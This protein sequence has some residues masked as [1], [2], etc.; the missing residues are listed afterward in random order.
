MSIASPI[1]WAGGKKYLAR[2]IIDIMKTRPHI[3]YCEPYCGGCQVLFA[4]DP[5]WN[6]SHQPGAAHAGCSEL[7]N[8][9]AG[10]LFNFWN[11][12]RIEVLFDRFVRTVNLIP[13]AEQAWDELEPIKLYDAG[14]PVTRAISFFIRCRQ[15]RGGES[16]DFVTPVRTRTRRRMQDHVSAYLSAVDGLY[17]V[18]E[19]LRRVLMLNRPALD[20]IR[21]ED[22]PGT[23]FYL[24][25]P[26][27]HC[28]RIVKHLYEHEMDEVDHHEL[29]TCIV[30]RKGSV[31]ISTYPN[32]QYDA[33]LGGAGWNYQDVEVKKSASCAKEKPVAV[34]RLWR[35]W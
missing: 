30:N 4:R 17:E 18:H 28:T 22:T 10:E 23:M 15:S 11:V 12:L 20:V 16:K 32:E 14:D 13:F 33:A 8:D 21:S 5:D 25:P 24:D 31:I 2:T 9:L 29:L 34:E 19:R 26:Y 27:P 1:K 6:W 35:N 7:I 3:H